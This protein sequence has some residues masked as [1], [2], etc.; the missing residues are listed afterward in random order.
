MRGPGSE[1]RAV[2]GW[3]ALCRVDAG[4]G[5]EASTDPGSGELAIRAPCEVEHA[6]TRTKSPSAQI[7]AY[8]AQP[9]WM[10]PLLPPSSNSFRTTM[11]LRNFMLL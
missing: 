5:A 4:I 2:S 1:L 6:L 3:A 7:P 8:H 9:F 10:L 11:R